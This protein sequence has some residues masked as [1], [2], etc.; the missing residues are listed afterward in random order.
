MCKDRDERGRFVKGNSN[1]FAEGNDA[2]VKYREEYCEKM[3]AWFS[4][5]SRPFPQ[6]TF[7]AEELG[8]G[9]RTLLYWREEHPRFA[10]CYARCKQIQ[11]AKL[12]EGAM[13]KQFDPSFSKFVA[14]NCHGMKEKVETDVKADATITVNIKEVD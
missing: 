4:D 1:R 5:E 12:M 14:I 11:L 7:F 2:A 13:F 3:L 10:D 8:V 6:F 9:D